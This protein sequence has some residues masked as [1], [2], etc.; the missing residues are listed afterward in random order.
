LFETGR[1]LLINANA[2]CDGD[3]MRLTATAIEALDQAIVRLPGRVEVFIDSS[4]PLGTIADLLRQAGA[5]RDRVRVV[6]W[7]EGGLEVAVELPSR[8][9]VGPS[10][11]ARLRQITG[12]CEVREF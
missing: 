12:V 10:T 5:G 7:I 6:S 3:T 8:H 9:A 2:V 11:A 4:D 1:S